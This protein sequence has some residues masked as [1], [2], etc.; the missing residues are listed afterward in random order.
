MCGHTCG[1]VGGLQTVG[2]KSEV[3]AQV[4]AQVHVRAYLWGGERATDSGLKKRSGSAGRGT[5]ACVGIVVGRWATDS[6]HGKRSRQH[7]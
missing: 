1:W 3:A 6:R 2:S 7:R 4:E 5:S